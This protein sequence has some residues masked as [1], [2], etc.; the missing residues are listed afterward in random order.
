MALEALGLLRMMQ[1][2]ENVGSH[3]IV[4]GV[5]FPIFWIDRFHLHSMRQHTAFAAKSRTE[6]D[7][8]YAAALKAGCTDSGAEPNYY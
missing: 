4:Y 2:L 5:S 1:M 6:V 7:T 3:A 8:F